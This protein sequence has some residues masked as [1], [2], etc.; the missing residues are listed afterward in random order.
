[1]PDTDYPLP[2]PWLRPLFEAAERRNWLYRLT[3]PVWAVRYRWLKLR[4]T[5][6]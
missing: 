3:L 1:M 2:S 6:D 4:G 5:C